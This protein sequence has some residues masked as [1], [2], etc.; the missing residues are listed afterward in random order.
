MEGSWFTRIAVVAVFAAV[1]GG[2]A[3]AATSDA[4]TSGLIN[5]CSR[6]G[7]GRLR[8][9]AHAD[10]CRHNEVAVS[11]NSAGSPGP[12]GPQGE[13]GSAGPQ[14]PAGPTGAA[15]PIGPQ[16]PAG[17][18]GPPGPKGDSGPAGAEGPAGPSGPQGPPGPQGEPGPGLTSLEQL[19]GLACNAGGVAGTVDVSCDS[20]GTAVIACA[21]TGG[22]GTPDVVVNEFSTGT[23]GA[24]ANEFVELLNAG[25]A[26]TDIGG[27]KVVYRS[28]S[29]TSDVTLATV[30]SGTVLAAGARYLLGGGAYV[31]THAADQ[32][33]SFG[34]AASGGGIGLR[35]SDGTLL[36][37]V[38]YGSATNAFVEGHA[39]PAPPASD[40]PGSSGARLPDGHDTDDNAADFAVATSTPG[41][42]N[43]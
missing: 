37:S 6:I 17:A 21:H 9:V 11:W 19:D 23:T 7:D 33:F 12:P 8:L 14:G 28:A 2:V 15:G 39:A 41:T 40:P 5:A 3:I 29:G 10:A 31:G 34:L 38:G 13:P 35:E 32:S 24:A 18:Q 4:G 25:T 43:G 20:T 22:G 1:G 36:D 27:F 16:G 30:P 26:S 42:A